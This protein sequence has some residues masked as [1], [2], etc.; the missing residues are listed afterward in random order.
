MLSLMPSAKCLDL[1]LAQDILAVHPHQRR[2]ESVERRD[3]VALADA[4][5][6]RVDV[7]GPGFDG[8]VSI[9]DGAACI[10]GEVRLDVAAQNLARVDL[11]KDPA[12]SCYCPFCSGCPT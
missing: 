12:S 6:S 2:H 11:V 1:V 7:G 4:E 5:H 3:A 9:R 8:D 10:V